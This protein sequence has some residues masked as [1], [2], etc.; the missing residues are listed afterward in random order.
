[1]ENKRKKNVLIFLKTK[2][3]AS[4]I[5][6]IT[7]QKEI[8]RVLNS[9]FSWISIPFVLIFPPYFPYKRGESHQG[10]KG[11]DSKENKKNENQFWFQKCISE[12]VGAWRS[13][14]VR[15]CTVCAERKFW[16]KFNFVLFWFLLLFL[17]KKIFSFSQKTKLQWK[18]QLKCIEKEKFNFR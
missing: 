12:S 7:K 14:W 13:V 3:N 8:N 4:D 2:T 11:V 17:V 15:M 18:I 5:E 1:M 6:S 16:F 10:I 9:I